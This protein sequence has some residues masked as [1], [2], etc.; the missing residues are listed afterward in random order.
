MVYFDSNDEMFFESEMSDYDI[1]INGM[2]NH[3]NYTKV[4]LKTTEEERRAM[5]ELLTKQ[6]K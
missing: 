1:A 2:G 5:R 4:M 6:K 3:K